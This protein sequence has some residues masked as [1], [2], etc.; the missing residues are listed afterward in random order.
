[1]TTPAG[2]TARILAG[3]VL[4]LFLSLAFVATAS[5]HAVLESSVPDRGAE[6]RKSPGQV[7]F[8]F[9]EKVEA[10]FGA[11]K[12]Y[13]SSGAE[14]P[15][16]EA[17]PEDGGHTIGTD[18]PEKLPAGYYTAIYRAVSADSHPISGGITFTVTSGDGTVGS[19]PAGRGISDLLEASD[20]G[21]VTRVAFWAARWAGFMAIAIAAG[22]VLWLLLTVR[23][24]RLPAPAAAPLAGRLRLTLLAA[25][26]AGTAAS[27]AA[28]FLQGAVAA[29]TDLWGAFGGG[30]PGEVANT[31]FGAMMLARTA[32]FAAF[33]PL[34]F[35]STAHRLER[36]DGPFRAAFLL[37]LA[38]SVALVITPGLAGHASTWDPVWLILPSDIVHV[39]AMAVWGGGLAAMVWLLPRITG[40]VPAGE[41]TG[42][43]TDALTRFSGPALVAVILIGVTG[44]IQAIAEVGRFGALFDTAFGRAVAIKIVLLAVLVTIGAINRRRV[45]PALAGRLAAGR[46]PGRTGLLARRNLRAEVVLVA[47]V[48]AVTAALVSY[49]PPESLARGPAAGSIRSNA[50][51]IEYTVDPAR[52][53]SNEVHVYVFDDRTGAP[54]DVRDLEMGFDPPGG[55]D[56]PLEADVRKAG[57]GHYVAPAVMMTI[58]GEWTVSLGIRFSRF[59]E[60]LEEFKVPVR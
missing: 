9:N 5:A 59:E 22:T 57:P 38:G 2:R 12:V 8:T 37:A 35:C 34:A 23:P 11:V 16:S 43:L 46:S 33:L 29:G 32:A 56:T 41:R 49:P 39:G 31:R 58:R 7:R 14:I 6:L 44:G 51:R 1:M 36:P 10:G 30:I 17:D 24:G 45:I 28:F 26:V 19:P 25:A 52:I 60:R 13:D 50:E 55:G 18:L 40:A 20:S 48:L 3:P 54:V 21:D 53:G 15:G 47:L 27:V 4:A 42:I